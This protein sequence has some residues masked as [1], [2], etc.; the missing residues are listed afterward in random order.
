MIIYGNNNN[1]IYSCDNS[2]INIINS[3]NTNSIVTSAITNYTNIIFYNETN[4]SLDISYL[5][6]NNV[7]QS[8][9]FLE[10]KQNRNIKLEKGNYS[11]LIIPQEESTIIY[12]KI[13]LTIT[14]DYNNTIYSDYLCTEYNNGKYYVKNN[15]IFSFTIN[16][17]Y[18]IYITSIDK[19]VNC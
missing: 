3:Y 5:D 6:K 17:Y 18:K 11:F 10:K 7:S 12:G 4:Y 9:T 14:D 19:N 15:K 16:N 13:Y 8:I 1:I 2:I